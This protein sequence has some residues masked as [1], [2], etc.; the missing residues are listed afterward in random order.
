MSYK[1]GVDVNAS[2]LLYA[3]VIVMAGILNSTKFSFITAG[4]IAIAL[5]VI[6]Y[7]QEAGT[8]VANS[9][10]RSQP[11]QESDTIMTV[12][13]LFSVAVV[14]WL[15]N[16]EIEKSLLRA[17]RSEA[18]L[19]EERDML[20][21]TVVKRTAQ[22]REAEAE[23]I[24]QLYRFAEFG[25]LSSGLFHDLMNPLT[26]VSL[27]I[28]KARGEKNNSEDLNTANTYLHSAVLAAKKMES[29]VSA[30]RKQIS[31]EN[32]I[33]TFSVSESIQ[34][35]VNILSYKA[36]L[37]NVTIHFLPK[38][39]ADEKYFI[40]G[41]EVKWDQAILNLITNAIDSYDEISEKEKVVSISLARKS[42]GV[43]I[44]IHDNGCGILK[45][46]LEKI[47]EPFFTTKEN[48]EIQGLGIGLSTTKRIIEK[49]FGGTL[50]VTST[51]LKGT[52]FTIH[53]PA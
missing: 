40:T 26:A 13:I 29:F 23:K 32:T 12:I 45:E 46:N 18:L 9:Y 48:K 43:V 41:K 5:F 24:S 19:K 52:T 50:T 27:N 39:V 7:L 53:L 47:F 21:V 42:G 8:I 35:V 36:Y 11:W 30:V 34:D 17:R 1:W 4:A 15:S 37:G 51:K 22:L 20:E 28:E 49:D 31:K 38:E 33:S 16:R 2:L 10:W 3:L 14:S 44:S 6:G 25:K